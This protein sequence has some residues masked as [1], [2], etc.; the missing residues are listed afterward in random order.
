MKN[1]FVS[2]VERVY[3]LKLMVKGSYFVNLKYNLCQTE[4]VSRLVLNLEKTS[5]EKL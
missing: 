2:F 3:L 4:S 1:N 5:Q